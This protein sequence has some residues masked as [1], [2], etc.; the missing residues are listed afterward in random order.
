MIYVKMLIGFVV[1]IVIGYLWVVF[2]TT[3]MDKMID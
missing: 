2:L 1:I 3:L